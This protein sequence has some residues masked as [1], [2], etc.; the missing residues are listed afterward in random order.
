MVYGRD[1][2]LG[3]LVRD[4]K[5]RRHVWYVSDRSQRL[6]DGFEDVFMGISPIV[7]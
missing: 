4:S 6:R 5:V 7:S 2:D 1:S 3:V